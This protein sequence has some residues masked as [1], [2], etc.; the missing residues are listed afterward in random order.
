MVLEPHCCRVCFGRI[1][2]DGDRYTCTNCG[3]SAKGDDP[4]VVCACGIKLRRMRG[5]GGLVDAGIRC[6]ANDK[7]SHEFPSLY[8]ASY[9]GEK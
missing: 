1:A 5:G 4:K 8:V 9:R 7:V 2:S 6:H 3:L